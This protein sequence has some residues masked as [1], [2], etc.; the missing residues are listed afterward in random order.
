MHEPDRKSGT[1]DTLL[2]T[3]AHG[4]RTVRRRGVTVLHT[5]GIYIRSVRPTSGRAT[6]A[7]STTS[8][9]PVTGSCCCLSCSCRTASG[10]CLCRCCRCCCCCCG[11]RRGGGLWRQRRKCSRLCRRLWCRCLWRSRGVCTRPG[12]GNTNICAV[13]E[14]F[15]L[16][17]SH[18]AVTEVAIGTPP[19]VSCNI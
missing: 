5:P 11:T 14:V 9:T 18:T 19:G 7:L 1:C 4:G 13:D 8:A 17:A 16:A 3:R 6:G 12:P 15:L 10:H 2:V